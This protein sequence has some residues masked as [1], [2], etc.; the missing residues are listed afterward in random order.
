MAPADPGA[1]LLT[2]AVAAAIGSVQVAYNS[3]PAEDAEF[4]SAG[5]LLRFDGGDPRLLAADLAAAEER[6]GTIDVIG[7]RSLTVPGGVDKVEFRAATA[8]GVRWRAPGTPSR[9]LPERRR[10]SGRHRRRGHAPGARDRDDALDGRRRTVVGIV[11]NPR[12]L[13]DEFALVSPSS[14]GRPDL[15]TVLVDADAAR[16]TPS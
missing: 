9:Q 12:N 3:A 7:H 13:S 15:V 10:R 11:E 16:W 8:R 4:G 6:L 5:Q 14:A 2:V 1:A